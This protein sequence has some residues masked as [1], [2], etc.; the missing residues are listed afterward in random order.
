MGMIKRFTGTTS[1]PRWQHDCEECAYVGRARYGCED[2]VQDVDVWLCVPTESFIL[3]M[4]DEID[5]YSSFPLGIV[6]V[7]AENPH[8]SIWSEA[9][10][11]LQIAEEQSSGRVFEEVRSFLTVETSNHGS[12]V[13]EDGESGYSIIFVTHDDVPEQELRNYV[14]SLYPET[15]CQHEHDCCGRAYSSRPQLQLMNEE[16]AVFKYPWH[17]NI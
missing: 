4:S 11:T 9:W 5:H 10:N 13:S 14:A 1:M 3:R 2:Q 17:L 6:K 8:G 16:M 7:L 12:V 15:H